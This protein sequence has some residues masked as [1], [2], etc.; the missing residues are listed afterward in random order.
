[1]VLAP[2]EAL[3]LGGRHDLSVDDEGGGGVVEQG[4]DSKAEDEEIRDR[5]PGRRPHW[6]R[7]RP[8]SWHRGVADGRTRPPRAACAPPTSTPA[9]APSTAARRSAWHS[10]S[11]PARASTP[12][13]CWTS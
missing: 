3:L 13:G 6:V 1:A 10:P 7:R 4:V 12:R 9:S 11:T 2:A 8:C 5:V